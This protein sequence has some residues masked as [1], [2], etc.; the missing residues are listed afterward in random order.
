LIH[1]TDDALHLGRNIRAEVAVVAEPIGA[2]DRLTQ[3]ARGGAPSSARRAWIEELH[4]P[5]ATARPWAPQPG[6]PL[7]MGA[8]VA[9]L[10]PHLT[11]DTIV[12]TDAG[13]FSGWVHRHLP[14]NGR[15]VMIGSVGGAM[16]IAM[17]A[18][19]ASGLRQPGRQVLTFIGD[20]GA[21]M[22]GSELAT[23]VQYRVPVKVFISSNGTYGTIRLHQEKAFPSRVAGT[24]LTNP[25]FAAWARSFGAA[26]FTIKTAEEAPRVVAEALAVPGPAVVDVRT[27]TNVL[28]PGVT[29]DA[30]RRR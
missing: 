14:F 20:G 2:L 22:T 29:V 13:N 19:V 27:A 10:I 3:L 12:I 30:L 4:R 16:G 8:V 11:D 6:A 18:A 26:G 7:D 24:E 15:Q 23:A 5:Q 9:A 28:A 21:L 17:P 1:I 25:D